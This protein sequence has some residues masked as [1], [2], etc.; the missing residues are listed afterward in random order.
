MRKILHIVAAVGF[1]ILFNPQLLAQPLN[2]KNANIVFTGDM[3]LIENKLHGDYR[4]LSSF[5]NLVRSKQGP[6]FFLFGGGSIGPS[7]MSSFDKGS[8]IIDILN[9][10]EPDAMGVTKREFSYSE[11]ELSQRA[12]EAAFP[13][14]GT[15][16]LDPATKENL[17]GIQ[18]S[19]IIKKGNVSIGV[20][21]IVNNSVIEEYLLKRLTIL[22]VKEAI[23][24]EAKKLKANG[25][26]A[27]VL[28]YSV[29]TPTVEM[30]MNEEVIDIAFMTDKAYVQTNNY[31]L[32][33]HPNHFYLKS[34][35][36]LLLVNLT[37]NSNAKVTTDFSTLFLNN[38][39]I[40]DDISNQSDAYMNRLNRLL[41]IDVAT[42]D[43]AV[44]TRKLSIRTSET[45]FGNMVTD[46]IRF[47]LN[48]DI[49]IIN[50][51]VIRGDRQYDANN[52][53]T[54]RDIVTELPFRS[55][56][57]IIEATGQQILDILEN[58]VSKIVDVKGRFP[59]VSGMSFVF[60]RTK[61]IGSRINKV[62]VA[63]KLLDL[64]KTYSI[65]TTNYLANGGDG[66]EA[67]ISAKKITNGSRVS[68]MLSQILILHMRKQGGVLPEIEG[69]IQEVIRD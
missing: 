23:E 64:D 8:H 68:P 52:T 36:E 22:P 13:I 47:Y 11:D 3:P 67:F 50:S 2:I 31:E 33:K 51:G 14:I 69:R 61:P 44:D 6:S 45:V 46:A 48:T 24:S 27:V 59:Q 35:G 42:F 12:Y 1:S 43:K 32:I 4:R 25:A 38:F 40:D 39:P 60:D 29:P 57:V 53:W 18:R 17:D 54:M 55:Q 49:A 65:G 26:D 34:P 58:G 5:L 10:L 56:L 7:P 19:S 66:Y 16:L 41:N 21:S 30:L 62:T 37:I 15:N 20:L 9:S 28:L 63:G